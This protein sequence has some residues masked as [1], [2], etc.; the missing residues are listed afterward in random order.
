MILV[1]D[2]LNSKTSYLDGIYVIT[3]ITNL[4]TVEQE[5]EIYTKYRCGGIKLIRKCTRRNDID[6]ENKNAD[7]DTLVN[8]CCIATPIEH[9][10]WTELLEYNKIIPSTDPIQNLEDLL[11][12]WVQNGHKYRT[13]GPYPKAHEQEIYIQD[14]IPPR[15]SE[16]L[17]YAI[18]NDVFNDCFIA[19]EEI[20]RRN[21]IRQSIVY[22]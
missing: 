4:Y 9:Q 19:M 11:M 14:T 3:F 10:I 12:Y 8:Q 18:I 2:L 13:Y 7:W 22:I 21:S 6:P 1:N 17:N 5:Q 15:I 20:K 16:I